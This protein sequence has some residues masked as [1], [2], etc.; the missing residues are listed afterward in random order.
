MWH[1]MLADLILLVHLGFV[2]FVLLGAL[3]VLLWRWLALA[4]VPCLVYGA[5]IELV[6]WVCPLTPLE[7][8]LRRH[9][10]Q[11]GYTGGFIEHYAGGLLYPHG[12]EAIRVW[13]GVGL[14]AFNVV[15]YAYILARS[16]R[17]G[18]AG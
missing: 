8:S 1:A 9:A 3:G 5:A 14:V 7:Q 10:G 12:W 4:H 13:L 11:E 18:R 17:E 16:R 15:L 2:V 6:G